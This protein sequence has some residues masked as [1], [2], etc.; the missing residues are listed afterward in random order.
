MPAGTKGF[1]C[2]LMAVGSSGWVD[3]AMVGRLPMV[4]DGNKGPDVDL[5]AGVASE[6]VSTAA[7]L[8]VRET[9]TLDS[10]S[11]TRDYQ[12]RIGMQGLAWDGQ[13]L[14]W[15]ARGAARGQPDA[16]ASICSTAP[17]G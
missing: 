16:P 13:T 1:M 9:N 15:C 2:M 10:T 4:L 17:T 14:T 8:P 6:R 5:T 11:T 12:S 7:R 3:G